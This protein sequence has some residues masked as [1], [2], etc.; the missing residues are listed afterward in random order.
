MTHKRK[1]TSRTWPCC[2]CCCCCDCH[3]ES[4]WAGRLCNLQ[5]TQ[6]DHRQRR[7][8]SDERQRR[9][10]LLGQLLRSDCRSRSTRL[11]VDDRSAPWSTHPADSN[12]LLVGRPIP[13]RRRPSQPP[14]WYG[15]ARLGRV[16][17]GPGGSRFLL[18]VRS[19]VGGNDVDVTPVHCLC[20]GVS[21][22]G[23]LHVI[24]QRC[25]RWNHRHGPRRRRPQFPHQVHR[26]PLLYCRQI[27][28]LGLLSFNNAHCLTAALYVTELA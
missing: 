19:G 12:R 5:S 8:F 15:A 3:S 9:H 26:Y 1:I 23:R 22:T 25:Q 7:Q 18:P 17:R 27:N 2:C 6:A 4:N 24:V 20:R 16:S 28:V 21:W 11:S 14:P 13:R 10:R